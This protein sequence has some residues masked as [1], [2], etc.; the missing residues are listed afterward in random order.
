M[1]LTKEDGMRI[2]DKHLRAKKALESVEVGEDNNVIDLTHVF[3][4][5]L[6]NNNRKQWKKVFDSERKVK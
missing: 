6:W 4:V 1:K 5:K 2:L 3:E